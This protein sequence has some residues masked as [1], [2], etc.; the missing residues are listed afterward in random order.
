VA[1]STA[2]PVFEID[3]EIVSHKPIF[4]AS[5]YETEFKSFVA[6]FGKK[7]ESEL[8]KAKRMVIFAKNFDFIHNWNTYN[9]S[10]TGVT[11]GVNEF[12]D[13]A[14]DEFKSF[15]LGYRPSERVLAKNPALKVADVPCTCKT[16]GPGANA[17]QSTL[18]EA[19]SIGL[20]LPLIKSL[21][22]GPFTQ[23]S[24]TPTPTPPTPPTP[25]G[26]PTPP[27][28][29]GP[30]SGDSVDWVSKGA[31]TPVK[32]QAHCGSCW[33]FS[34][35]GALEGQIFVKHG[36]L[37]SLSEEELVQCDKTDHGCKGGAMDNGFDFVQR[38]GGL[39]SEQQ[40][41]YTTA[42]GAGMTGECVSAKKTPV[43]K[44]TSGVTGHHDVTPNSETALKEAVSAQPVSVAVEADKQVFQ[45]YKSGVIKSSAGCG[46]KLDHGVLAV[47]YGTEEG[48]MYW[49]IK[50]S[51]GPTWGDEGY[52]KIERTES[53]MSKGTCGVAMDASYPAL[54]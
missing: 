17:S 14:H 16:Y 44:Y 52:L 28:P 15:Y 36:V 23:C 9:K 43:A 35:T 26:P 41:P 2:L 54:S 20:C 30:P 42:T 32:N 11:V 38:T 8:E 40:Y 39:A 31:V 1:I 4:D 49:K 6:K 7:Y 46:T 45:F 24:N 12:A 22:C 19:M 5:L 29:P 21:G 50:N 25:P 51:W 47:G 13:L 48:T 27:T 18:C 3:N 37:E 53:S 34:T 33:A 10:V